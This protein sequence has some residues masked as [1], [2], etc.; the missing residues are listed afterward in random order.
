MSNIRYDRIHDTHVIIAPERLHRPDCSFD[1][2]EK[3]T[4]DENCPFCEGNESMTPP[5]IFSHRKA[6][7]FPNEKGWQTRVVPNLYKAVQIEASYEHHYG[8]FEHWEGFG[9]HEVIIDTPEH[10]TSM[11]QWSEGAIVEW[12]KTLRSR[13]SDLRRDQRISH[14]SLFKNE[15]SQAGA[16]QAHSHTQIIG[17]PIIPKVEREKYQRSYEYYKQNGRAMIESVI[18]Q[19]E[20]NEER[21][22]DKHGDFTAFCPF[23]SAYP[24]EV[25]ISSKKALG[26]INTLSDSSIETLAPLL[27]ATLENLK[28]Q[29][30]C[31]SFNLVVTTPPL[32]EDTVDHGLINCVDE[33]CRFAI[34]IM[35]RIY[36]FGGFEV[37][38]GVIINPVLPE[39]AAKLLR[40]SADV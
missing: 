9:A 1:V 36:K 8:L 18:M 24:F 15:G 34:R 31:F 33:A 30:G 20:E 12:L 21:I 39:V 29:L 35:P 13:V 10:H 2:D 16:T 3:K 23:A 27:L 40:E 38:T 28:T 5:E 4:V 32:Q 17:L 6:G 22:I 11:T 26:Q 25:M 7:S 19:E 14:I 37:S